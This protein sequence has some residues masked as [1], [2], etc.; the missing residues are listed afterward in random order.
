MAD[1]KHSAESQSVSPEL[2]DIFDAIHRRLINGENVSEDEFSN[3]PP[4]QAKQLRKYL[5]TMKAMANLGETQASGNLLSQD[6]LLERKQL[7]EF[8]ILREVGRGGM[9]VVYE[10]FQGTLDRRVALKVLPMAALSSDTQIQRFKNEARAAAALHHTNIVPIHSIGNDQGVHY[11]AMQFIEGA[12]LADII[13]DL[14]SDPKQPAAVHDATASPDIPSSLATNFSPSRSS[15]STQRDVQAALTT[16]RTHSKFDYY[17]SVAKWIEHAADA[18]AH[19][20]ESGVLHRDI[21]P[22]NLM[23]DKNAKLWVTDFGL[24]R[25]E[26]DATMTATGDLLGTLRYMS[27][28]QVRGDRVLVD[29]RA[30]VYSLGLTLYEALTLKP[31]F[32]ENDRGR[33]LKRI[34]ESE[35]TAVRTID[36]RTPVDLETIILKATQKNPIDRYVSAE[37]FAKDLRRFLDDRPIMAKRPS[38]ATKLAKW[39]YRH[40]VIVGTVATALLLT[41]TVSSIALGTANRHIRGAMNQLETANR[42]LQESER[43][44][45]AT[46]VIASKA[47]D[48]VYMELVNN[49]MGIQP[50]LDQRQREMLYSG[51]NLYQELASYY[52]ATDRNL[53]ASIDAE[54]KASGIYETLREWK[55]RNDCHRRIDQLL[56]SA[57]EQIRKTGGYLKAFAERNAS[58]LL[59][60]P[61]GRKFSKDS[62]AFRRAL[63]A[64]LQLEE[65]VH[66]DT[67]EIESIGTLALAFRALGDR[68]DQPV[69]RDSYYQRSIQYAELLV[70]RDDSARNRWALAGYLYRYTPFAP[71]NERIPTACRAARIMERVSEEVPS[72]H[73]KKTLINVYGLAGLV[74]AQGGR[75]ADSKIYFEKTLGL[76]A[77]LSDEY[78]SYSDYRST[79]VQTRKMIAKVCLAQYD[80]SSNPTHVTQARVYLEDAKK[81]QLSDSREDRRHL[82]EIASLLGRVYAINENDQSAISQI[83][84]A[85]ELLRS[86]IFRRPTQWIATESRLDE[87]AVATF[88]QTAMQIASEMPGLEDEQ[89]NDLHRDACE[90]SNALPG[91]KLSRLVFLWDSDINVARAAAKECIRKLD[92]ESADRE[93]FQSLVDQAMMLTLGCN[94]FPEMCD[95]EKA[96]SLAQRASRLAPDEASVALATA[97]ALCRLGR[98]KEALEWFSRA[99]NGNGSLANH[100]LVWGRAISHAKLADAAN[101]EDDFEEFL[102]CVKQDYVIDRWTAYA[103]AELGE[104]FD[105]E[106]RVHQL[107][108]SRWLGNDDPL[109]TSE[110][111]RRAK[112]SARS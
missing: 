110:K 50:D 46:L 64:T 26:S 67:D 79:V 72:R 28:E 62:K 9:G 61:T 6:H 19:A 66:G 22:G 39:T 78:P 107:V 58:R 111:D 2:V 7:G 47:M 100:H 95:A 85:S 70:D 21:K 109:A 104:T 23:I 34:L 89:R 99:E 16:S 18:L 41:L 54:A 45:Q 86:F 81:V 112:K 91:S 82:A 52:R 5:A 1:P 11:Y 15:E 35:P 71:A 55:L 83:E 108:K 48:D 10:A 96:L 74:L 25:L 20:H 102:K 36:P 33:L 57:D 56:S 65:F 92:R 49:W 105:A 76:A 32:D 63:D 90:L 60:E 106:T 44:A 59:S 24:A 14:Q 27:P 8:T 68:T 37:E 87:E 38:L 88:A 103:L 29:H 42:D 51:A 101:A 40:R 69:L 75:L 4:H 43:R 17:R 98:H 84:A 13:R 53:V 12:T 93:D 30:D 97:W 77:E 31:A 80:R 3:F 73:A 94:I